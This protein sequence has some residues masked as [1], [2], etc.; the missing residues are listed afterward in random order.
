MENLTLP[1]LPADGESQKHR[2][3]SILRMAEQR[4]RSARSLQRAELALC[5]AAHPDFTRGGGER[6]LLDKVERM[7]P[8]QLLLV[9]R[10]RLPQGGGIWLRRLLLSS[11]ESDSI[12]SNQRSD[13]LRFALR[14]TNPGGKHNAV[15]MAVTEALV[16]SSPRS[17]LPN[18]RLSLDFFDSLKN[19]NFFEM[20]KSGAR[21][22]NLKEW[23]HHNLW[24]MSETLTKTLPD[25][26]FSQLSNFII[27]RYLDVLEGKDKD[28]IVVIRHLQTNLASLILNGLLRPV[29]LHIYADEAK[30]AAER[31]GGGSVR[32][33]GAVQDFLSTRLTLLKEV[34]SSGPDKNVV[35]GTVEVLELSCFD[36]DLKQAWELVEK[37]GHLHTLRLPDADIKISY[38]TL[39]WLLELQERWRF[40]LV[41]LEMSDLRVEL[42]VE[43]DRLGNVQHDLGQNVFKKLPRLQTMNLSVGYTVREGRQRHSKL[44][45]PRSFFSLGRATIMQATWLAPKLRVLD[46]SGIYLTEDTFS[47]LL[48][49]VLALEQKESIRDFN[50]SCAIRRELHTDFRFEGDCNVTILSI[51]LAKMPALEGLTFTTQWLLS[52]DKSFINEAKTEADLQE[53]ADVL[54]GTP[55]I[56]RLNL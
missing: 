17:W 42:A 39:R 37:V 19:M 44:R 47:T 18:K 6:M 13:L 54:V 15:V 41:H 43:K 28:N 8:R 23:N 5:A 21:D 12:D 38:D 56:S 31:E 24:A 14:Q 55:S 26:M 32:I 10:L 29:E 1:V 2:Q 34:G 20:L 46:W 33:E 3:Q 4:H 36:S 22:D 49:T 48:E 30:A 27:Q 25:G 9:A 35:L 40:Y 7:S 53:I 51:L 50:Y 11:L 45:D 52:P 16:L